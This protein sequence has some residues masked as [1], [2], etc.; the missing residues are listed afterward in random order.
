MTG[1]WTARIRINSISLIF[2]AILNFFFMAY[3]LQKAVL[4]YSKEEE[5]KEEKVKLKVKSSY[6]VR[7]FVYV[8][9]LAVAIITG[10]FNIYTLLIPA[11]FPT[12]VAKVRMVW[13][14]T[15]GEE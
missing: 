14:Q 15:H 5:D 3:T 7:S 13:L 11:L 4:D 12:M 6:A 2:A 8:L 10:F 1:S 9:S